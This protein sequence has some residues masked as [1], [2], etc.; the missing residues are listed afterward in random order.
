MVGDDGLSTDGNKAR[1]PLLG[2]EQILAQ[3]LTPMQQQTLHA[4]GI[5][6]WSLTQPELLANSEAHQPNAGATATPLAAS[7]LDRA[8]ATSNSQPGEAAA[9]SLSSKDN[10]H[11]CPMV[12]AARA[13][14]VDR[15][16]M[17]LIAQEFWHDL[18]VVWGIDS[19]ELLILEED[20]LPSANFTCW[21]TSAANKQRFAK[22][23]PAE[24][25]SLLIAVMPTVNGGALTAAAKKQLWS[26]L[27]EHVPTVSTQPEC[28]GTASK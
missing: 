18:C 17:A 19:T 4:L 2:S 11:Q 5:G 6:Q 27:Y 25:G 10:Q 13:I 23:F 24:V 8:T 22:R 14:V 7:T 12:A 28:I 1:Q 16:V 20:A 3:S 26:L 9:N 21:L 15:Q